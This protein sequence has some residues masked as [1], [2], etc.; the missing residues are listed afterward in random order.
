MI[1]IYQ[2]F[3]TTNPFN[4]GAVSALKHHVG[5][6]SLKIDGSITAVYTFGGAKTPSYIAIAVNT[7]DTGQGV[8]FWNNANDKEMFEIWKDSGDFMINDLKWGKHWDDNRWYF[9][10]FRELD[11]TNR[12]G[13][14]YVDG[15]FIA[16]LKFFQPGDD[17][18]RVIVT[19]DAAC[20]TYIDELWLADTRY[21]APSSDTDI[22]IDYLNTN[23]NS[24][25]YPQV[26]FNHDNVVRVNHDKPTEYSVQHDKYEISFECSL[27]GAQ[28][29][30]MSL[31]RALPF[32]SVRPR[33]VSSWPNGNMF[34]NRFEVD[35]VQ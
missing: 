32:S 10:E 26:Y 14:L 1:T 24:T 15:L 35:I 18:G 31:L 13:K 9:I 2:T 12:V 25:T 29:A 16:Y 20:T 7:N 4:H 19:V 6:K 5:A 22:I 3:E 28:D 23:W 17:F 11:Y 8:E 30:M 21:N 27:V 33:M 34:Y